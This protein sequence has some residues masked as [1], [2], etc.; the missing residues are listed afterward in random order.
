MIALAALAVIGSATP[1]PV[2]AAPA[3]SAAADP[4]SRQERFLELLRT[5]PARAPATS[6][7][8]VAAL[9]D[10]GPFAEHD[11]AEYWLGSARLTAGDRASARAWLARLRQDHPG[12][13]WVE[14]A[15]L[16]EGDAAAQERSYDE[17]LA[18]YA[19]A[20]AA[21]APD[22]RELSRL[23]AAQVLLLRA[24]QRWAIAAGAFALL[25]FLALAL[26][27][28]RLRAPLW[29]P[30]PELRVVGPVLAVLA[31]L[32]LRQDPAP[33]RAILELCAGGA[34]LATLSGLRLRA[35]ALRPSGRALHAAL[36]LGALVA[37][38]YVAVYRGDLVGMVLETFRTGPE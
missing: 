17:S 29:P 9:V 37:L 32:S 25:V 12:S 5:Y 1:A 11:R 23:A 20:A 30:P 18:W 7:A 16:L 4:A 28:A 13:P 31:V 36:L 27:I 21:R 19:R 3:A 35:L 14:R 24:R 34:L 15:A 2:P 10:E 33:R 6:M 38:A 22:V 26:S 8:L